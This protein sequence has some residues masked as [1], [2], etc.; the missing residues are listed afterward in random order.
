MDAGKG[1]KNGCESFATNGGETCE[2]VVDSRAALAGWQNGYA[3]DCKSV[4]AG[5]IPTPASISGR[6]TNE[7]GVQVASFF[8]FVIPAAPTIQ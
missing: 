2:L 4:D 8:Y 5:S 6:K 1:R 3:A 7:K